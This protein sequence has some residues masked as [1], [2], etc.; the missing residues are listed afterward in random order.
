MEKRK[1]LLVD[2]EANIRLTLGAVLEMRGFDVT[3][4]G[5]VSEAL[6]A[7]QKQKY[8]VLLSDLNI[9]E[10]YD[11]FTVASATRRLHPD[12]AT[13]MITGYPAFDSA[14]ESIRKQVD[15]YL[16]KPTNVDELLERIEE[17][18]NS[19]RQLRPDQRKRPCELIEEHQDGI[20]EE[21]LSQIETDPELA[22]LALDRVDRTGHLP[23]FLTALTTQLAS[24]ERDLTHDCSIAAAAHGIQRRQRG[25]SVPLV[26][27]ESR[28]LKTVIYG[29][30]QQHLLEIKISQLIGEIIAL[31]VSMTDQLEI[32]VRA[33][34][35]R[36][37]HLQVS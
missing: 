17:K 8:D 23:K 20:I 3:T 2:D 6:S 13:V 18:L 29:K 34:M 35:S 9:G 16:V 24:Y 15:D 22:C 36:Q 10:P 31:S 37:R 11:G 1:L 19:P 4:A 5:T 33:F 21:W 28:I 25:Y 27:R 32:S 26:I 7:I 30:L 12:V 14:L